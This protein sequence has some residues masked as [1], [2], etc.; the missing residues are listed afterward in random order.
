MVLMLLDLM[1][2][3]N[4][5]HWHWWMFFGGPLT[6]AFGLALYA[7][8][9]AWQVW[10]EYYL[11]TFFAHGQPLTAPMR[12]G[13]YRFVRHPRYASALAGKVAFALIFENALGWIM[14]LAWGVSLLKKVE[15]EETHRRELFGQPYEAY[16]RTT[17]KLLPGIY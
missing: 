12:K 16:Q 10:M 6:Q 3:L 11:A 2:L 5:A 7:D 15:T 8:S 14:V 17:A 9:M 1:V 13:P 4:Y